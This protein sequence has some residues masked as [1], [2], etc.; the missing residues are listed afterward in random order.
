MKDGDALLLLVL[1]L[2]LFWVWRKRQQEI[3]AAGSP[4]N[5]SLGAGPPKAPASSTATKTFRQT[6]VGSPGNGPAPIV[7]PAPGYTPGKLGTKP[8]SLPPPGS[9]YTKAAESALSSYTH[10]PLDKVG[11]AAQSLGTAGKI[12]FATFAYPTA[13]AQ[14]LIDNPVGTAKT[15]GSDTKKAAVAVGSAAASAGRAV[16]SAVSHAFSSIF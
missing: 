4:V 5:P 7:R 3:A 11:H 14:D 16:G 13:F 10:V 9:S 8:P 12:A 2:A 1:G 6:P 15:I